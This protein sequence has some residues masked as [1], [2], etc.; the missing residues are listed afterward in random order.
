MSPPGQKSFRVEA[1][2]IRMNYQ[3]GVL[4]YSLNEKGQICRD[5]DGKIVFSWVHD[6]NELIH[7]ASGNS[8]YTAPKIPEQQSKY[9]SYQNPE[10]YYCLNQYPVKPTN[11]G[12]FSIVP[13]KAMLS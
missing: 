1:K 11:M 3:N 5:S 10:E 12:A 8:V 7:Y 4:I 6:I 9:V 13:Q 2:Y